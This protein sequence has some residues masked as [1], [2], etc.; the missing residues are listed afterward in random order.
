MYCVDRIQKLVVLER[1]VCLD[2]V[3]IEKVNILTVYL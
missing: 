1:Q 3:M 2:F